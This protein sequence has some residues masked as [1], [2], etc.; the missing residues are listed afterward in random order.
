MCYL[1]CVLCVNADLW[2]KCSGW[3]EGGGGREGYVI[4]QI[5]V[6]RFECVSVYVYS[7]QMQI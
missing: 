2:R 5:H 6:Q 3:G 7:Q 1:I 4:E